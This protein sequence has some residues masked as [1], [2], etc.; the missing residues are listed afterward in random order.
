M[1]K[2]V[3]VFTGSRADFGILRPLIFRIKRDNSLKLSLFAGPHHFQKKTGFTDREIKKSKLKI[4]YFQ[5]YL[6]KNLNEK[7]ILNYCGDSLSFFAEILKK[8]KPNIIILLGDR[9]EVFMFCIVAFFFNIPIAHIHGGEITSGAMDD[10]LRHSISKMSDI[11]FV[12]HK[13]YKKRVIQ[14]GENPQTVFNIG[15][16]ALETIKKKKLTKKEI[17]FKKYRIPG[18]KKTILITFHP[19]TKSKIY[20]KQ[21]I[22]I[23]LNSLKKIKNYFL[24]FT[25]NNFDTFGKYFIKEITNF[26]KK[27]KN[28]K[29]I[30]SLG[31]DEYHNFVFNV[32]LVLGNSSSG[33]IEV[34]MLK[35]PTLNIG[36]RQ[37]GRVFSKS[38]FQVDLNSRLI[39]RKIEFIFNRKNKYIFENKFYKKNT[40]LNILKEIKKFVFKKK[41]SKKLFYD[42]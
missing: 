4:N 1:K 2:K 42:L 33:V 12:C 17:L 40:S 3:L 15:S 7:E 27:N 21:Q 31:I 41:R 14:L 39:S 9:Y 5:K 29:I 32:D 11:H 26:C 24:I 23:L 16:L 8:D 36:D 35:T 18:D 6:F 22:K 13:D 38:I 20:V 25:H 37:N 28:S 19:E 10:A 34:P 30:K